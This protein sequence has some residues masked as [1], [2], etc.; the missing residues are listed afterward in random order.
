MDIGP[1]IAVPRDIDLEMSEVD[2]D[3]L[4]NEIITWRLR[5]A[6]RTNF[7]KRQKGRPGRLSEACV[8]LARCRQ[9]VIYGWGPTVFSFREVCGETR[10]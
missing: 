4:W 6:V 5:G 7:E 8:S 2:N 1:D 9:K 10:T 3:S